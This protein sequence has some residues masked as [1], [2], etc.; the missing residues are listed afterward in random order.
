MDG[1]VIVQEKL[2]VCVR[3][4]SEVKSKASKQATNFGLA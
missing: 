3:G 4:F 1:N 2:R